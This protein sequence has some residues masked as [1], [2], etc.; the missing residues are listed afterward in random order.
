MGHFKDCEY[1]TVDID[2]LEGNMK[3]VIIMGKE[4]NREK[5][6][7]DED[8]FEVFKVSYNINLMENN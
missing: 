4:F 8:F 2:V 1:V 3:S 5:V 6:F 7:E